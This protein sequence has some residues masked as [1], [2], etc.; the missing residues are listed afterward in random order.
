MAA[1]QQTI[2]GRKQA[3]DETSYDFVKFKMACG[4]NALRQFVCQSQ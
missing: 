3:R 1:C 2:S 4:E